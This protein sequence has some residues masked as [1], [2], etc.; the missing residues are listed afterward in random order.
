MVRG[1]DRAKGA[2]RKAE[3][4]P[5][6]TMD[7]LN[8]HR[9]TGEV[10]LV[11]GSGDFSLSC[12]VWRRREFSQGPLVIGGK[13][14]VLPL[15]AVLCDKCGYTMLFNAIVM[16]TAERDQPAKKLCGG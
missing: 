13:S 16:G 12:K 14:V 1:A 4:E 8:T 11:C 2:G 6:R 10:C 3:T 5:K 9:T 7:W 15:V